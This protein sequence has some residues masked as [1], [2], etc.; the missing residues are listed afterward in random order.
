VFN[1]LHE[2][3]PGAVVVDVDCELNRYL[4][5]LKDIKPIMLKMDCSS[6]LIVNQPILVCHNLLKI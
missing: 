1:C 6:G 4:N 2:G 5:E 3:V